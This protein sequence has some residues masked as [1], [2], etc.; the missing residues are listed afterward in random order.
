MNEGNSASVKKNKEILFTYFRLT[1]WKIYSDHEFW[2]QCFFKLDV[3]GSNG[4]KA[5]F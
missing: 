4:Y 1:I 2:Q 3:Y 5:I